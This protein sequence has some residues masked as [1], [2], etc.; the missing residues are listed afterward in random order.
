MVGTGPRNRHADLL[1]HAAATRPLIL[2]SD[3]APSWEQPYILDHARAD[4]ADLPSARRAAAALAR[5]HR[6]AGVLTFDDT[7]LALAAHL[8]TDLGLPGHSSATAAALQ[9][10]G[11]ARSVYDA[12]GLLAARVQLADTAAGAVEAADLFGFPVLLRPANPRGDGAVHRADSPQQV[13]DAFDTVGQD[14]GSGFLVEEFVPGTELGVEC[15]THYGV[16]TPVA[17]T[18]TGPASNPHRRIDASSVEAEDPLLALVGPLAVVALDA[19]GVANAVT[20]VAMRI[21]EDGRPHLVSVTGCLTAPRAWLVR[22]ATGIDLA[23]AA[24]DLAC[25]RTPDLAPTKRRAA[26]VQPIGAADAQ[27][28]VLLPPDRRL[29]DPAVLDSFLADMAA[30]VTVVPVADETPSL[31]QLV[32]VGTTA[33]KCLSSLTEAAE[34]LASEANR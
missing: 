15:V 4:R 13:H 34:A 20:S 19:L 24:A 6:I 10:R 1:A 27:P 25:G 7:G 9:D 32:A 12:A 29:A 5:R 30:D 11:V 33:A 14:T 17:I 28:L 8:S 16:T 18:R 2:I 21:S 23:R 3:T 31:Q 26:A 22:H